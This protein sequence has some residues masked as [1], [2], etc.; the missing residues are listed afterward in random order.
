[1]TDRPTV[2]IVSES[3]EVRDS[4]RELVGSAG[5]QAADFASLPAFLSPVD[6]GRRGCLVVDVQLDDLRDQKRL[7]LLAQACVRMSAILVTDR[8][9]VP[10]AVRAVKV[11]AVDIVEKPY[12]EERLLNSINDA[13][14]EHGGAPG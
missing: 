2:F 4:V 5:L 8:G 9:D 7:A 1:M 13:L 3:P 11:G 10:M 6:P 14:R 12:R